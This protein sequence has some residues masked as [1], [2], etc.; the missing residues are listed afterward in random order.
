[1]L[2]GVSLNTV[3][4][5]EQCST[6][7]ILSR[8]D[9]WY[10]GAGI[11]YSDIEPDHDGS[12]WKI[13]DDND[14]AWKVFG[15][16]NFTEHLF[17]EFSF[18]NLGEAEL[19]TY[20][21]SPVEKASIEHI[22][23]GAHVGY[24]LNE[25][26]STWNAYLKAGVSYLD[27]ED[28]QYIYPDEDTHFSYGAG[29]QYRFLP[30]W[31]ARLEVTSYDND[32]W[33]YGLSIAKYFGE[34]S[35]QMS[36]PKQVEKAPVAPRKAKTVAPVKPVV[37]VKSTEVKQNPDIDGDGVLNE[38][39]Q[40]PN[41]PPNS[42]VNSKG[43]KVMETVNLHVQFD[44]GKADVNPEFLSEI[45]LVGEKIKQYKNIEITVE[46]H[47][48]WQGKQI[49]NQPLSERRAQA[50]ATLLIEKSGINAKDVNAVGF[51]ELKP[52]ADNKTAEGRYKN[53]RVVVIISQHQ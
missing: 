9:C 46:G 39:D 10:A 32:A 51:G 45:S 49:N 15:G 38:A 4:A 18:E 47:T 1:M 29:V 5:Q 42:N 19:K 16:V 13:S 44:T 34:R 24:L 14:T 22:A 36:Q 40:C 3:A 37:S 11:G 41:T 12:V 35:K 31:L 28:S 50:V 25:Y 30:T 43:C 52:I 17:G 20:Q 33:V 8:A 26:N 48:D 2:S 21:F 23:Y 7:N 53:R 27:I 6:D